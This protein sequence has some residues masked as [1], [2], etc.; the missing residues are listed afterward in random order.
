MRRLVPLLLLCACK[1]ATPA[2]VDE[3]LKAHPNVAAKIAAMKKIIVSP[4]PAVTK[5]EMHPDGQVVLY[6]AHP[7]GGKGPT[8]NATT[9]SSSSV[10]AFARVPW[11]GAVKMDTSLNDCAAL[12]ENKKMADGRDAT[13]FWAD[14]ALK[15]CD[16]IRYVFVVEEGKTVAPSLSDKK[17]FSPGLYEAKV[18]GY[19]LDKGEY[20]GSTRVSATT[21]DKVTNYRGEGYGSDAVAGL[22]IGAAFGGIKAGLKKA[23]PRIDTN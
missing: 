19:D 12:I 7:P 18:H 3:A 14:E 17:T 4:L 2:N 22:L 9:L 1:P 11:G 5:D 10:G 20:F 15:V 21:A 13:G 16:A 6:N 23:N 8:G